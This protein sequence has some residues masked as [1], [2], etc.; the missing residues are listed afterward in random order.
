MTGEELKAV[1]ERMKRWDAGERPS[2]I[3]PHAEDTLRAADND[4]WDL[5]RAYVRRMNADEAELAE[6]EKPIDEEWLRSLTCGEWLDEDGLWYVEDEDSIGRIVEYFDGPPCWYILGERIWRDAEPTR[7]QLLD[8][9]R[10]LG[11][12]TKEQP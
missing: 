3:Y 4:A 11:V 7:G 5:A 10:A 2:S 6:R 9:L 12:T 8:L 1:A